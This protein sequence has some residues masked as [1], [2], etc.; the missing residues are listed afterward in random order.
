MSDAIAARRFVCRA[1]GRAHLTWSARCTSCNAW[2]LDDERVHKTSMIPRPTPELVRSA[3]PPTP[4]L[5]RSAGPPTSE[6]SGPRLVIARAPEPDLEDPVEELADVVEDSLIPLS[7]VPEATFVRDSTGL[8]PLDHVLGGGLVVASV[9]L[10]ASP[11]GIGKC[12]GRGTPVLMFD[13]RVLPVECILPGD[14]L[15]GPDGRQRVVLSTNEGVG[16]LY[17]VDPIKGEAWICNEAHVLTLI[18]SVTN[19]VIDVPLDEWLAKPPHSDLR[20]WGKL[21]TVG[22]DVFGLSDVQQ[23]LPVDPYFLGLWFGDGTKEI[24]D[25]ALRVVAITKPD[26]EVRVTCEEVARAWELQVTV[27][28]SKACP[29]YA[30]TNGCRGQ[31][32]VNRLLSTMRDLLGAELRVPLAYTRAPRA[33]RL[34]FLAGLLDSDGDLAQGCFSITQKREDWARAVWWMAR[35]LGLCATIAAKKGRYKRVDGSFF[36]GDY[37]RVIISGDTDTIP[38]RIPRKKAPPRQQKKVATRT[39]F[40][41]ESIGEGTYYGFTLDGDGRFLLGDFTVTH[42]SSLT[43]QMLNGLRHRCLYVTGEETC[44]QVAA[45]A[46]RI[47]AASSKIYPFVARYLDKIFAKARVIG[48]QTIAIDSIQKMLCEDVS[49]RQGSPSQLKECTSRLVQYAKTT[50]TAVWLIGHVT[51]DGDIQGPRTLEHDVDVLLELEQGTKFDGNERILRCR[52]KNRFGPTGD[53]AVGYFELT[54][55]GFVCVDGDGWDEE[56]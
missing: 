21:F 15:M 11:P 36:E 54:A 7:E 32:I 39:G 24:Q 44:E 51:N 30:L 26:P 35:S 23:K 16:E 29:T 14:Q 4:E 18:N 43:L 25:G 31:G 49:G 40:I 38:T 13:G 41:I 1:C 3:G 46:R 20:R 53:V 45:T 27:W 22:I 12:L 19:E 2:G 37:W 6:P 55:K 17:R 52:G 8:P 42:N 9:V 56:L 50:G 47:G 10:L 34:Q 33:Q 5:V 28:D 48:A